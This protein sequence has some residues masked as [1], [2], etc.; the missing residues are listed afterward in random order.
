MLSQTNNI[1]LSPNKKR[2]MKKLS[3]SMHKKNDDEPSPN[4]QTQ[5]KSPKSSSISDPLG[6]QSRDDKVVGLSEGV[7]RA[8]IVSGSEHKLPMMQSDRDDFGASL[9]VRYEQYNGDIPLEDDESYA[10]MKEE[11]RPFVLF[12]LGYWTACK[13]FVYY[14]VSL[15]SILTLGLSVGLTIYWYEV[16]KTVS[17]LPLSGVDLNDHYS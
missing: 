4:D 7:R 2:P 1:N 13:I 15:S 8:M 14:L 11:R 10:R 3:V 6:R 9:K 5:R 16:F 17:I 12:L